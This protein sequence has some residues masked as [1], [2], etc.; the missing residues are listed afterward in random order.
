MRS[1]EFQ[2]IF[3]SPRI[4]SAWRPHFRARPA[5]QLEE[6]LSPSDDVVAAPDR[7][8]AFPQQMR[9]GGRPHLERLRRRSA[10]PTISRSNA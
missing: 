10:S 1:W 2:M 5:A 4:L 8:A 7:L 9:A 6:I 3:D